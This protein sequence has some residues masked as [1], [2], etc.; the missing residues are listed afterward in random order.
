MANEKLRKQQLQF[1]RESAIISVVFEAA[2]LGVFIIDAKGVVLSVNPRRRKNSKLS[3]D[4]LTGKHY[5]AAFYTTLES[6]G[7]LP[8]DD[9]LQQEGIS[10]S[11]TLPN[12]QRHD[13]GRKLS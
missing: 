2:P 13:D 3:S 4:D 7:L 11:V 10:F 1:H 6:Q 5:R 12:Y 9:G 8:Y